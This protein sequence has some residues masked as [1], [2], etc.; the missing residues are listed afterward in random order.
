MSVIYIAP[1]GGTSAFQGDET[2]Y[3][4]PEDAYPDTESVSDLTAAMWLANVESVELDVEWGGPE[5][6]VI[7][8]TTIYMNAFYNGIYAILKSDCLPDYQTSANTFA[9]NQ[10]FFHY[11]TWDNG[12]GGMNLTN[13]GFGEYDGAHNRTR[14]NYYWPVFK[15][16]YLDGQFKFV[17]NQFEAATPR[18]FSPSQIVEV[19][20]YFYE[21]GDGDTITSTLTLTWLVDST[22]FAV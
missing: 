19:Y 14:P 16:H 15:I 9:S 22:Y 18:T 1:L 20:P 13:N 5:T 3:T 10:L 21:D 11:E 6:Q 7:G 2:N 4:S 8:G 12:A 17:P